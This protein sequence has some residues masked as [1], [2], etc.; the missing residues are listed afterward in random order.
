MVGLGLLGTGATYIM[1][2]YIVDKLGAIVASSVCYIP[3]VV[4]LLIGVILIGEPIEMHDY[5]ATALI[6]IGVFLLRKG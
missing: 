6:F 4:A 3:P 5:L 2:Y 1:Y